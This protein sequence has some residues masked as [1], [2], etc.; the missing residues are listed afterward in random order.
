MNHGTY[1]KAI[2]TGKIKHLLFYF[3][4]GGLNVHEKRSH[5]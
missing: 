2:G 4:T 3:G 5:Y 1:L